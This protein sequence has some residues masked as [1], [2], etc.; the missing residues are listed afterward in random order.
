[1][2]LMALKLDMSKA[3]DQAE[4]VY[5]EKI[6]RKMGFSQRWVSLTSMCIRSV[7]YSILL[8]G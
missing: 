5:L 6:M 2:G 3:Y 8:N 4:W 7:S 1:M